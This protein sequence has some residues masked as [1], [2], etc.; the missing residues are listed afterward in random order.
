MQ[1]KSIQQIL[2]EYVEKIESEKEKRKT[3]ANGKFYPSSIGKCKRSIVYQ[4]LGY[5][6]QKK[7]LQTQM[8]LDNG[9][10][11]HNR[12]QDTLRKT[13]IFIGDEIPLKNEELH[14]SARLD[15]VVKNIDPSIPLETKIALV[16][17]NKVI[18]SGYAQELEVLE[19]K[20]ISAAGFER[21]NAPKEEHKDQ[22]TI[23][24]GLSEI[25]RGRVFYENKNTQE[26]IEFSVPYNEER[27][28]TYIK[29]KIKFCIDHFERNELPAK[30]FE[31]HDFECIYCDYREN[32]WPSEHLYNIEDI[33]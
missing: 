22:L 10:Y 29:P 13:N 7:D 16:K 33:L 4:M 3:R 8:I 18:Y 1:L 15:A 19:F 2:S 11:F 25:H 23:Y 6:Q 32:C 12:I 27:M 9:T 20:S 21:L 14:I 24:E 26:M 5:P 17:D 30:E 31:K 28:E